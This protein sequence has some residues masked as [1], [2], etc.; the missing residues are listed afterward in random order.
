MNERELLKK[1]SDKEFPSRGAALSAA[2]VLGTS[3]SGRARVRSS[4]LRIGLA[5]A[6]AAAVGVGLAV[7]LNR[8]RVPTDTKA[9]ESLPAS[10]PESI[11]A[12]EEPESVKQEE[13]ESV[14][15][16]DVCTDEK[17]LYMHILDDM[18]VHPDDFLTSTEIRQHDA[19]FAWTKDGKEV[20]GLTIV[21]TETGYSFSDN[22][23]GEKVYDVDSTAAIEFIKLIDAKNGSWQESTDLTVN[24]TAPDSLVLFESSDS[25]LSSDMPWLVMMQAEKHTGSD[26]LGREEKGVD[27]TVYFK[28]TDDQPLVGPNRIS[29]FMDSAEAKLTEENGSDRWEVAGITYI[30]GVPQLNSIGEIFYTD[31]IYA[32]KLD[33]FGTLTVKCGGSGKKQHTEITLTSDPENGRLIVDTDITAP[34]ENCVISRGSG[35]AA[36]F[37]TYSKDPGINMDEKRTDPDRSGKNKGDTLAAGEHVRHHYEFIYECDPNNVA[38]V[39]FESLYETVMP[40]WDDGLPEHF[41]SRTTIWFTDTEKVPRFVRAAMP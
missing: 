4:G 13:P 33:S 38:G 22:S 35:P 9:A 23:D 25:P 3:V 24:D 8:S 15:Q 11:A 26:Q 31:N 10:L 39:K 16:D 36:D 28:R 18:R 32:G 7:F 41:G 6:A 5:V 2:E 12:A 30:D 37:M 27:V 20:K 19:D 21:T 1:V 40:Y 14:M 17:P 29:F 34:T